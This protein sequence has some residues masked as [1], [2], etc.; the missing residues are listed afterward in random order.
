MTHNYF[1]S[2]ASQSKIYSQKFT[3]ITHGSLWIVTFQQWRLCQ[4]CWMH[5][6]TNSELIKFQ[7]FCDP[8]LLIILG[9]HITQWVLFSVY[10]SIHSLFVY[11]VKHRPNYRSWVM[12]NGSKVSFCMGYGNLGPILHRFGDIAGFLLSRVT[13]PIF[14]PNFGGVPVAP[15]GPCSR[16]SLYRP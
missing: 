8:L 11:I 5:L 2:P 1:I 9:L 7:F 6:R 3:E 4:L 14:R 10:C 16:L 12:H 13:P 15:D